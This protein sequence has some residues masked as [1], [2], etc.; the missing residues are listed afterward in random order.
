MTHPQVMTIGAVWR[1]VALIEVIGPN[2]IESAYVARHAR[3]EGG[4]ERCEPESQKPSRKVTNEKARD[5]HV[6]VGRALR[7]QRQE[8]MT[9][10]LIEGYRD[11]PGNDE[12]SREEHLGH[13]A[14]QGCPPGGGE[15][16]CRKRAL[17]DEEV[18]T[19]VSKGE[20][21]PEAHDEPEPLDPHRIG[22][23]GS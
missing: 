1:D 13:C 4:D 9:V 8:V 2:R 7:S 14:D 17:H 21:E 6:V 16:F 15:G 10:A 11:H 20:N 19:P 12:E 18:R 23:W 22:G 5:T 3:H